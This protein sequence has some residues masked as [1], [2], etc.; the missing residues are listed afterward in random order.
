MGTFTQQFEIASMTG[1]AWAT[2]EGMVDT[3]ATYSWVPS[4]LL[5]SLH[6]DPDDEAEFV[7]ADGTHVRYPVAWVKLRLEGKGTY[8]ICVF[9]EAD[10]R[11]L[12]GAFAL[13]ALRLAVDPLNKR[14]IPVPGYLLTS[15]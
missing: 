3:G 13:E 10:S 9:G 2:V 5:A 7:L 8:S 12:L 4:D 1:D 14:L 11:P 15:G 6:I